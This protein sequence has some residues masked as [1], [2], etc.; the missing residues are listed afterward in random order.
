MAHDYA[1]KHVQE[2]FDIN[3]DVLAVE[4]WKY[5]DA[6]QAEADKRVKAKAAE[7]AEESK[8]FFE[9][10]RRIETQNKFASAINEGIRKA[11]ELEWQPDWSQAPDGFNRFVIGSPGGHG[12]FTNIEPEFQGDYYYI[13]SDG[14]VFHNHGYQGNWKNSLRKRPQGI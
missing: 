12:F 10:L 2:G 1:M 8:V 9:K 3:Y 4:A 11:E 7:D 14:V 13:G 5:A 6:M